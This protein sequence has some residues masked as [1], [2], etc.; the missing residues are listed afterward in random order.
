MI[1]PIFLIAFEKMKKFMFWKKDTVSFYCVTISLR[2]NI[3][4]DS[5]RVLLDL[6]DAAM[7][8][9]ISLIAFKK[10]RK[11][12]MFW[13]K[14]TVSLYCVIISLRTNIH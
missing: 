9:P 6:S 12:V 13:K 3:H 5:C 14:N 10:M 7:I 11:K 2:T 4:N 1:F 8:F